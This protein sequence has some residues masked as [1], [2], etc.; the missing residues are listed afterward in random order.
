MLRHF[1]FALAYWIKLL[2][3]IDETIATDVNDKITTTIGILEMN[4][5]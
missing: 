4:I 3:I 5:G 2:V 1:S